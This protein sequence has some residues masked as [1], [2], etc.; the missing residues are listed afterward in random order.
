M[1]AARFRLADYNCLLRSVASGSFAASAIITIIINDR[2]AML[3]SDT[4]NA[5]KSIANQI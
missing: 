1:F 4:V 5:E 3:I 2:T